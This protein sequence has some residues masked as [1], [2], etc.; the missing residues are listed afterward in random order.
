MHKTILY[1]DDETDLQEI[2][3]ISLE[4]ADINHQYAVIT[5]NS[6]Q[7][8]L[9]IL[10]TTKPDLI[11]LDVMMPIMDGPTTLSNIKDKPSLY[12]IPV[13]FITAKAYPHEIK[14]FMDMGASSV[15]PK[16]FDPIE[17]PL[18]IAN[19][20]DDHSCSDISVD[21]PSMTK[22]ALDNKTSGNEFDR[23]STQQN[24]RAINTPYNELLNNIIEPFKQRI[25]DSINSV[26]EIQYHA[27]LNASELQY[28]INIFHKLAG[29]AGTIGYQNITDYAT[30]IEERL[31]EIKDQNLDFSIDNENIINV[32]IIALKQSL[33]TL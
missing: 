33:S 20:L 17:L 29:I 32:N 26:D 10:D 3:K 15:I 14:R 8:A 25:I 12:D 21:N 19:V 11:L 9:S 6:G 28:S 16:P 1:A 31:N 18:L 7:E 13:V 27:S 22:Q 5:C 2:T 30:L 24:P 4:T 23:F